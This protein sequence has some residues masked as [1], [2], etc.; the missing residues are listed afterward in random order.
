MIILVCAY[1]AT[2]THTIN[3]EGTYSVPGPMLSMRSESG[4]IQEQPKQRALSS[5]VPDKNN[6]FIN[7]IIIFY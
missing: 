5:C 7:T 6:Y 4:G 3:T 2:I 1:I